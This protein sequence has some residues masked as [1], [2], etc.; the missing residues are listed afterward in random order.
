MAIG[1]GEKRPYVIDDSL[2]D[3]DGDERHRQLRP[4]RH[5]RRRRGAADAGVQA[6]GREPA[7]DAGLTRRWPL[8]KAVAAG[9]VAALAIPWVI[10]GGTGQLVE[11]LHYGLVQVNLGCWPLRLVLAASSASS[12]CS[13]GPCW[14]GRTDERSRRLALLR[15]V[16]L[17]LRRR[18]CRMTASGR[19]AVHGTRRSRRLLACSSAGDGHASAR[20]I[21]LLSGPR[22]GRSRRGCRSSS[23][24]LLGIIVLVPLTG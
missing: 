13:P 19:G 3:R 10:R 2:A 23:P 12:P 4:P 24:S 17:E 1:A 6:A 16:A 18:R 9:A 22:P 14:P 8:V 15:Q 5:R 11:W 21:E 20:A 7:G